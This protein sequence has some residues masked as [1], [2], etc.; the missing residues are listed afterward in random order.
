MYSKRTFPDWLSNLICSGRSQNFW[1]NLLG[2]NLIW[3]GSIF[4]GNSALIIV[5]LLLLLHF[6]LHSTPLIEAQIVFITALLGYCIDCALTLL[7]FF[8]FE[9][10]QGI[11]PFWLIFLWI[12]FCCTLRE[13]L[14]F[15]SGKPLLSI[16]F[17]AVAGSVAYMAAA[18]FGA[19]QLP[20]PILTS[21]LIL[22]ALWAVLFPLLLWISSNMEEYLCSVR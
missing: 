6:L 4:F 19:V 13:S 15:F 18:N 22:A 7:G 20:L 9:K 17:G 3:A 5:A 1:L 11:T 21:L 2:F 10:V 16:P 14:V 8:Q 12:G